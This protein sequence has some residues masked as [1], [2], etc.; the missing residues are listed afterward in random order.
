LE[1]GALAGGAEVARE[2][3]RER[4]QVR[5]RERGLLTPGLDTRELEQRVDEPQQPPRVALR[6]L[7]PQ[8]LRARYRRRVGERVLERAE[9]QRERRPKLVTD[10]AEKR[11][12]RTIELREILGALALA[13]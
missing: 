5:R 1:P 12:L 7:E 2:V 4:A 9:H 13:R 8:L 11:R 3:G 6:D 10:V